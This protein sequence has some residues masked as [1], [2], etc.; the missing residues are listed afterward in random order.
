MAICQTAGNVISQYFFLG[1]YVDICI[2]LVRFMRCIIFNRIFA[3]NMVYYKK[4][5][6]HT[7]VVLCLAYINKNQIIIL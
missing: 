6:D 4:Y 1:L 2:L 3:E 7:E 5:I